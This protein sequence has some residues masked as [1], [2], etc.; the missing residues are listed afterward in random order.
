[1]DFNPLLN[2][3]Q[4]LYNTVPFD[5][6]GPKITSGL[7]LGTP[8]LTTRGMKENEIRQ[9]A[10]LINDILSAPKSEAVLQRVQ[11]VISE[12]CENFPI[13]PYLDSAETVV[14]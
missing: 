12:I 5:K 4:T 3:Y 6:K 7:R 8:A 10:G 13:Y 2:D 1:M 9:I 14:S 11:G